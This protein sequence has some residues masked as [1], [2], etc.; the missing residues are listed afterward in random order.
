M[1]GQRDFRQP[2]R[3][4]RVMTEQKIINGD[5]LE[6]MK[7]FPD[8]SFDLIL[9]D[10]PYNTGMTAASSSTRLKNFFNDSY[11]DEAYLEL[12]RGGGNSNVPCSK[13]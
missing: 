3:P 8:K 9:T 1:V 4:T 10:P 7:T 5:C 2:Q 11:T 12:V 13:R 6:V